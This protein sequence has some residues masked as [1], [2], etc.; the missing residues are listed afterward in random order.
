MFGVLFKGRSEVRGL[1]LPKG[2]FLRIGPFAL[3][4]HPGLSYVQYKCTVLL[5]TTPPKRGS[6]STLCSGSFSRPDLMFGVV[7]CR[8]GP[9]LYQHGYQLK[10]CQDTVIGHIFY[11]LKYIAKFSKFCFF[12]RASTIP[13]VARVFSLCSDGWSRSSIHTIPSLKVMLW[14]VVGGTWR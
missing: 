8:G 2:S 5:K 1:F 4:I 13:T 9:F 3:C 6:F 10:S 12:A 14:C 11:R 7:S